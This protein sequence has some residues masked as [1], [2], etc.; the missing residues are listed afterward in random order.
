M[1][2][3]QAAGA[4]AALAVKKRTTPLEVPLREIHKLLRK[5]GAIIPA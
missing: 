3:G 5:Y 2:M 4:T 1:A